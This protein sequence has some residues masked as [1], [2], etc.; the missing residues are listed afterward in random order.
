LTKFDLD[1]KKIRLSSKSPNK[2]K[3]GTLIVDR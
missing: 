2:Y 1:T 3:L